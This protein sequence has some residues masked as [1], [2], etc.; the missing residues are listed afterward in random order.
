MYL[1]EDSAKAQRGLWKR[2][3]R[4][5]WEGIPETQT[6]SGQHETGWQHQLV[7][8]IE[9]TFPAQ[10]GRA[11]TIALAASGLVDDRLLF[12]A[13]YE[14]NRAAND[15]D[16]SH[17]DLHAAIGKDG[18]AIKPPGSGFLLGL[19]LGIVSAFAVVKLRKDNQA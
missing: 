16:L 18:G 10:R 7:N 11:I 19:A 17:I 12:L 1:D 14:S 3:E 4:P 9:G 13:D 2:P 15:Q 6:L 8:V 5:V